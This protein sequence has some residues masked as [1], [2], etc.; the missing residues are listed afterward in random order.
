M[1][2]KLKAKID[3]VKAKRARVVLDHLLKYGSITT[4]DL[5]DTY[6]YNHPPRAL[7]DVRDHGIPLKKG[8]TTGA[9]G[10]TMA[11]YSLDE[12]APVDAAKTGRRPLT[13][14]LRHAL[15]ERDGETCAL[16]RGHFAALQIDHRVPYE[17]A[18]EDGDEDTA[19]FMLVCGSCNRAK[20]WSCEHCP[21]RT[22]KHIETCESCLWASPAEYTHVATEQKR[23]LDLVWEG[24]EVADYDRL[25]EEGDVRA[26]VKRIVNRAVRKS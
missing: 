22:A 13:K 12:T 2:P 20:S 4:A 5:K 16:C 23:R 3:A 1:D 6:G 21:N 7:G 25:A 10:R 11:V 26:A 8:R 15:V 17:I 24:P 14:A 9:D 18:G 19:D